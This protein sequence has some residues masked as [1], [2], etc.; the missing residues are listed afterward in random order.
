M[1]RTNDNNRGQY[2]GI[3]T[4]S[5]AIAQSTAPFLGALVAQHFGF[6]YLWMI[7]AFLSLLSAILYAR[8]IRN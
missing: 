1:M 8:L 6:N 4:M 2:A 5:W 3:W 7:I